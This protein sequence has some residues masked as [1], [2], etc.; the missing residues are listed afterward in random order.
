MSV[1]NDLNPDTYIGLSF[2]LGFAGERLFNR[3]KTLAQ[4]A[5]YNLRNLLLT[6]IGERPMQPDFG[7]RLLEVVFET[8]PTVMVEEVI[9]EAVEK[10][11]PYIIIT[12]ITSDFDRINPHIF[13]VAISFSVSTSAGATS[14]IVLDFNTSTTG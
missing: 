12:D 1:Q 10:W 3:T 13:N 9:N 14:Q 11:L 8:E 4:Q 2:P 6:N 7:S 5:E